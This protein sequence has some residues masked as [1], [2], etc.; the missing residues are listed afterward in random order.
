MIQWLF[1]EECF[2]V[3]SEERFHQSHQVEVIEVEEQDKEELDQ[4]VCKDHP[5][6]EPKDE[7][8]GTQDSWELQRDQ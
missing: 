3:Q 5:C 6:W 1:Q 4:E 2:L 8:E 7:L